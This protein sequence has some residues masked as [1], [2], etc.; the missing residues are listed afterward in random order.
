[1][2]TLIRSYAQVAV[3][4]GKSVII[5]FEGHETSVANALTL[6][7]M[8]A[9]GYEVRVNDVVVTDLNK[10]TVADRGIVTLVKKIKAA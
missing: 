3:F 1:M 6:A 10:A 4:P 8:P 2:S 9:V 7:E 5:N